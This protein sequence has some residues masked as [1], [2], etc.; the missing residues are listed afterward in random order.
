MRR[1][2][3]SIVQ[4]HEG[5][6]QI[7]ERKQF[8]TLKSALLSGS[9]IHDLQ[10]DETFP[11]LEGRVVHRAGRAHLRVTVGN[12]S[13]KST[14]LKLVAGMLKAHHRERDH[15]EGPDGWRR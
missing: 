5:L 10:P 15:G 3:A 6:S 13:G 4:R 12:G 11:A 14:L 2:I 9:L 1:V 7:R 8:A